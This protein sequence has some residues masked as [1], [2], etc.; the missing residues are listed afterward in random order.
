MPLIVVNVSLAGVGALTGVLSKFVLKR[1]KQDIKPSIIENNVVSQV[2]GT[3]SD[4]FK[5]G[6]I[7]DQELKK[8]PEE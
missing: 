1:I 5:D 8:I 7:S 2:N 4:S 6:H 3:R